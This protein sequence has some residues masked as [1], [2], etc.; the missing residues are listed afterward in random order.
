MLVRKSWHSPQSLFLSGLCIWAQILYFL[1]LNWRRVAGKLVYIVCDDNR[2][3]WQA[4]GIPLHWLSRL[5]LPSSLWIWHCRNQVCC[6]WTAVEIKRYNVCKWLCQG[7]CQWAN[8]NPTIS[9]QWS[10][11]LQLSERFLD[12]CGYQ[13]EMAANRLIIE[14]SELELARRMH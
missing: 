2:W 6:I 13:R 3:R 10:R 7:P 11:S 4:W 5:N 14:A 12:V 8:I 1:L 9:W